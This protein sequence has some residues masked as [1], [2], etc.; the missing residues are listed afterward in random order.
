M[1][2]QVTEC[3]SSWERWLGSRACALELGTPSLAQMGEGLAAQKQVR[4]LPLPLT[5]MQHDGEEHDVNERHGTID[6]RQDPYDPNTGFWK[7]FTPTRGWTFIFG[8]FLLSL[9]C[10]LGAGDWLGLVFIPFIIWSGYG[11]WHLGGQGPGWR[12]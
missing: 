7:V 5:A 2:W 11:V 3:N 1:V 6:D 12:S 8:S 4:L 10:T 9:G